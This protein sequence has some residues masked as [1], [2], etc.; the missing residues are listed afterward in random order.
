MENANFD[1]PA[2]TLSTA[3]SRI[4]LARKTHRSVTLSFFVI[5]G[6]LTVTILTVGLIWIPELTS[7]AEVLAVA[8]AFVSVP[9]FTKLWIRRME[10]RAELFLAADGTTLIEVNP[11][12]LTLADVTL[13][14]DRITCL[15]ANAEQEHYSSGGL[16]G[17]VMAYR[18]NLTED[19]PTIG[20]GIGA[21]MGT[22]LR[23]RLYA[24]GAKSGIFLCIGV[25]QKATIA[26]PAGM[27]KKVPGTPQRGD[28]PGRIIMPFGAYLGLAELEALLSAVREVPGGQLFPSG[29]VSGT[30]NWN[31]AQVG[32]SE[33]REKIWEDSTLVL[34]S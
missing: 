17:E 7:T 9:F 16:L 21:L 23:R 2:L 3:A 30:W 25:D 6:I 11:H 22:G 19:R 32:A 20:R 4:E 31:A 28:D 14:Y 12:G 10:R 24:D 18:L 29:L 13:P 33:T 34:A 26:A 27:V 5:F 8:G 1:G 15:Y